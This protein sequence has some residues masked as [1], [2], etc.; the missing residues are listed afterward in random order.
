MV[1]TFNPSTWGA[2]GGGF[3]SSQLP[4][5]QSDFQDSQGYVDRHCSQ[6]IE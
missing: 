6:M 3:L 5:L 2:E 4:G 1:H